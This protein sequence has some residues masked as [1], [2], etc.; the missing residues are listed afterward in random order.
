M[1]GGAREAGRDPAGIDRYIEVKVSYDHDVDFA[2]EACAWWAALGLTTD[3]K[4]GVDDP[5]ELERLA[6]AH[7]DRGERRFIV[8]DDPQEVVDRVATYVDLGFRHLV[9]HAPGHDQRRFLEQFA[10]DV[11]PLMRERFGAAAPVAADA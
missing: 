11:L 5:V 2:R 10:A 4:S 3:E 9:F 1:E 8:S 7:P 6:D